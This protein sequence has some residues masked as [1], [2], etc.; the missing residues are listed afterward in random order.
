[1]CDLREKRLDEEDMIGE[2]QKTTEVLR[3][4][5]E[6]YAKK[7]RLVEQGLAAI[8][9]DIMEFQKEKQGRLNQI[10]VV[11]NL[12]MHQVCGGGGMPRQY[13]ML[14]YGTVVH[15]SISQRST[16]CPAEHQVGG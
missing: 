11:I 10:E 7:Q 9:S 5:K 15:H 14:L 8:N 13:A 6:Q 12:R 3:K 16:A 1:M 4:E 2:F